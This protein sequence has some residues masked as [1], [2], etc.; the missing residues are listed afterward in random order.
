[1]PRAWMTMAAL[2]VVGLTPAYAQQ[3]RVQQERQRE[4]IERRMRELQSELRELSRRLN[5]VTR[6]ERVRVRAV[7]PRAIVFPQNRARLGVTVS[8]ERNP[9]VDSIGAELSGVTPG[10][11]A[12]RAGLRAGDI[13]TTFN[14]ERLAGRYPVASEYQSEPGMK[15]VHFAQE[16][17]DGD[18][19][20][21]EYRRGREQQRATI[22][23]SELEPERWF[24]YAWDPPRLELDSLGHRKMAGDLVRSMIVAFGD[25]WLDMELVSLNPEL[26]EYFGT[27]E[28]LLVIR[29]PRDTALNLR[30][31]DVILRIDGRTPSSHSQLM[32]VFRSYSV[33]EPVQIEIMRQ[34]R[35][36]TVTASI[37]ERHDDHDR[38]WE[39]R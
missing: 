21:V 12:E 33:G 16:L 19:V 17:D 31:G 37:P 8:T 28:G 27:N 7:T 32:R 10:G 3:E 39:R 23:A 26:G 35:R 18:T 1:M 5:E 4:E 24:S 13:V 11:P 36:M 9:A 38:E 14:G 34:K 2:V 22:I 20:A 6:D 30:S 25:R 29:A 15:L